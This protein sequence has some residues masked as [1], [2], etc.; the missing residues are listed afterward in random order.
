MTKEFKE[1]EKET[2][3]NS[4]DDVQVCHYIILLINAAPPVGVSLRKSNASA[5]DAVTSL[6]PTPP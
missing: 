6:P 4:A 1:K 2:V 3:T 5:A